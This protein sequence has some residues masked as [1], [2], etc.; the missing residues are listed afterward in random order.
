VSGS[1]T[2]NACIWDIYGESKEPV[3][4]LGGTQLEIGS[5]QWNQNDFGKIATIADDGVLTVW[6][7]DTMKSS[8]RR[9][10]APKRADNISA[11]GMM[12]MAPKR[13]RSR[14]MADPV[15]QDHMPARKAPRLRPQT[16]L[17]FWE[18]APQTP[19]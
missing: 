9:A 16:M 10:N 2:G 18:T 3:H 6:Q 5:V 12:L 15:E 14:V 13:R 19:K 17:D 4:A 8:Q 11:S 7:T 1:S